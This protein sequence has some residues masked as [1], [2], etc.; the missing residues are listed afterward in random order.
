VKFTHPSRR[1]LALIIRAGSE[2]SLVRR[3]PSCGSR[4]R[5]RSTPS[6]SLALR[7]APARFG[8]RWAGRAVSSVTLVR[9]RLVAERAVVRGDR[10][11]AEAVDVCLLGCRRGLGSTEHLLPR[12]AFRQG[13]EDE[14]GNVGAL[15]VNRAFKALSERVAAW[16]L[17]YGT[18]RTRRQGG[19]GGARFHDRQ[20]MSPVVLLTTLCQPN[21]ANCSVAASTAER[22]ATYSPCARSRLRPAGLRGRLPRRLPGNARRRLLAATISAGLIT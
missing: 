13:G 15:F 2:Q 21:C 10:Q 6:W 3:V 7:S 19:T 11:V 1:G 18:G 5:R 4:C 20:I 12:V 14:P 9:E 22:F 16:Q 17:L 8:N